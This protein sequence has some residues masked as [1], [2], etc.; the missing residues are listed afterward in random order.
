MIT[1]L[2]VCVNQGWTYLS[3][4]TTPSMQAPNRTTLDMSVARIRKVKLF[5]RQVWCLEN[6]GCGSGE[7]C[8]VTDRTSET[9]LYEDALNDLSNQSTTSSE[10]RHQ[11]ISERIISQRSMTVYL[12]HFC[13]INL[14]LHRQPGDVIRCPNHICLDPK[15]ITLRYIEDIQLGCF[16]VRDL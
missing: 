16:R 8:L 5:H 4:R 1:G 10:K 14:W 7:T 6:T 2:F 13:F 12:I 3:L 9:F 15:L 11:S